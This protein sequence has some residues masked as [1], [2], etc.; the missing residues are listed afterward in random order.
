MPY[1]DT[2]FLPRNCY[3]I[4]NRG[5]H[6]ECVFIEESNYFY[7]LQQFQKYLPPDKVSLLAYCLMP[8]HYHF[9]IELVIECD[10]SAMMK[11]FI[12]SYTKAFNLRYKT[13]GHLFQGRFK[14][15][16]VETEDYLLTVARYIHNNPVKSHLVRFQAE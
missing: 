4:Y 10:L 7:F 9:L 6:R 14:C 5:N 16:P 3:H 15:K 13:V 2:I 12:I 8:N 1:R 11:N